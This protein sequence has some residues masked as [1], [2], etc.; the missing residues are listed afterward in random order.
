[1]KLSPIFFV[2]WIKAQK[3]INFQLLIFNFFRCFGEEV[4]RCGPLLDAR[5]SVVD[6]LADA[7][8]K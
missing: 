6:G 1:M 4:D 3:T 7:I 5:Q 2:E 8:R